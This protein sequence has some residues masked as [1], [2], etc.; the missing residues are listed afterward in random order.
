MRESAMLVYHGSNHIV[1]KPQI[2]PG[3]KFLDFGVGFYTTTN[4]K[5]AERWAQKVSARRE[6]KRQ[7]ISTYEVDENYKK[8]L[9][10]ISFNVPNAE[11]LNFVCSCRNGRNISLDYDMVFGPVADDNVYSTIVLFENGIY[12]EAEALKRLKIEPL[13][14]QVLF[15]TE[16]S[17]EF[18]RYIDFYELTRV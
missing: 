5:Q 13:F 9:R 10:V 6:P 11:W 4:K 16:K 8:S 12:D 7:L 3:S 1:E 2:I 15:H 14:N 18:C 17:L